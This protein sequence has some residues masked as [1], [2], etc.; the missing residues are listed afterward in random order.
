MKINIL[1]TLTIIFLASCTKNPKWV[2]LIEVETGKSKSSNSINFNEIHSNY[3]TVERLNFEEISGGLN[4]Y[5]DAGSFP[6]FGLQI[7]G[8]SIRTSDDHSDRITAEGIGFYGGLNIMLS[9]SIP[10]IGQQA[11]FDKFQ[12][13]IT[14]PGAPGKNRYDSSLTSSRSGVKI[15]IDILPSGWIPRYFSISYMNYV[16]TININSKQITPKGHIIT[17]GVKFLY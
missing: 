9:N 8:K 12:T 15:N 16:N 1:A 6:S 11:Y 4:S 2:K 5:I 7:G 14:D 3:T 10:F 17:G 13:I